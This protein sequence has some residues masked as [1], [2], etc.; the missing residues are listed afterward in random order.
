MSI[1]QIITAIGFPVLIVALIPLRWKLLP[2]LF[3]KHELEVIDCLTATGDVVLASLGGSLEMPEARREGKK[4][5]GPGD[6]EA[7]AVGATG[8]MLWE[9]DQN[10]RKRPRERSAG[11]V[12]D[13]GPI[14]RRRSSIGSTRGRPPPRSPERSAGMVI[15]GDSGAVTRRRPSVGSTRERDRR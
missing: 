15:G 14:T 1:S 9:D 7:G 10:L 8:W 12:V 13:G 2:R 11:V 6:V 5:H 4:Q 3:I